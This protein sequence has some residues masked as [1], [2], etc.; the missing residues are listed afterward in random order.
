MAATA[1]A[2]V[3]TARG[4]HGRLELRYAHVEGR[5]VAHDRHEGPLRVLKALHPEGPTVCHHVLV[6]PPGGVVGGDVLEV[7]VDAGVRAHALVTTPGATRFYRSAREP[8]VQAVRLRAAEGARLEWLPLEAIAH[9]GCDATN[10]VTLDLAPG[11]EAIGWDVLALGLPASDAP[12]ERGRFEQHLEWPGVWRERGR[13][14]AADRRLLESPLGLGGRK[15]VAT[16]WFAAGTPIDAAR[17]DTLLDAARDGVPHDAHGGTVRHDQRDLQDRQDRGDHGQLDGG[18]T[19]PDGRLVLLRLRADRV[20]PAMRQLV[21]VW[22]RWRRVA[23][24]LDAVPP[25]VWRT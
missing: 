12:F 7:D 13:I 19:S 10:R 5:T 2:G 24:S 17:R 14:D 3:P 11:A 15:I 16:M 1:A 23:W 25:R 9:G 20:E 18:A 8:A 6:H 21:R 4:W 22:Q